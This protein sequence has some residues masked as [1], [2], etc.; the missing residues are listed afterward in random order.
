MVASNHLRAGAKDVAPYDV[1]P[2]K[3]F[4]SRRRQRR[5]S[6]RPM[7]VH[8]RFQVEGLGKKVDEMHLPDAI[9]RG[10]KR[11]QVACQSGR[12]A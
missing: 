10:Q 7:Q 1:A 4:L 2:Y 6:L 5:R 12:I 9:A 8:D 11:H 3:V